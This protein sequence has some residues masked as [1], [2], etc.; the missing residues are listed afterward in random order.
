M[1]QKA[2][3]VDTSSSAA[4]QM[5]AEL[6]KLGESQAEAMAAMQK[7]LLGTYEQISRAWLERVKAEADLW[8]E[9]AG[10]ISGA[11]SVPDALEA[12]RDCV[13]QRMQMAADDGRKLFDDAQKMMNTLTKTMSKGLPTGS[14]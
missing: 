2:S 13:A 14:T 12:Y 10:K 6:L 3:H 8:S 5:P 9:L 1:A 4:Q 7:E 11:R